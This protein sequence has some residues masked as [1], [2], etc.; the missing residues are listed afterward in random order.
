M[1]KIKT[2]L[3]YTHLF[4]PIKIQKTIVVWSSHFSLLPLYA[5]YYN[6]YIHK[7]FKSRN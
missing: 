4:C 2:K 1:N 5:F 6:N 3:N 7:V